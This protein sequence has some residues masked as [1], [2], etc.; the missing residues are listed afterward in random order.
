MGSERCFMAI[1]AAIVFM[2]IGALL[3]VYPEGVGKRISRFYMK[4]PLTRHAPSSQFSVQSVYIRVI[5]IV[6]L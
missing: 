5:G 6:F 4:Y 3:N 2:V 1:I